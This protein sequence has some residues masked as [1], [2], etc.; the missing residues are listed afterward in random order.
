MTAVQ[1]WRVEEA[2]ADKEEIYMQIQIQMTPDTTS[3]EAIASK[4]NPEVFRI[5][6][7][8]PGTL[9]NDGRFFEEGRLFI[10]GMEFELRP[11][12][13]G[14]QIHVFA[15]MS[16]SGKKRGRKILNSLTKVGEVLGE[17]FLS[18]DLWD[19]LYSRN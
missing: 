17:V 14:G 15:W 3:L 9:D 5:K 1:A 2:G 11:N 4:F 8:I 10:N 13:N 6:Y 19:Y 12:L 16:P 7:I 18:R